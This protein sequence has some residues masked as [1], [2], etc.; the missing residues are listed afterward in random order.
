M[1]NTKTT[2]TTGPLIIVGVIMVIILVVIVVLSLNKNN[3][4]A[5]T[6]QPATPNVGQAGDQNAA[7]PEIKT[8]GKT[9]VSEPLMVEGGPLWK[10][11]GKSVPQYDVRMEKGVFTPSRMIVKAGTKIQMAFQAVD[12]AYDFSIDQPNVQYFQ[13]AKGQ[14]N[15]IVFD[16][17]AD[18]AGTYT[19][20][21][22]DMCPSGQKME[23]QIII[24]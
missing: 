17:P 8:E 12:A 13:V 4:S 24:Q 15:I 3:S 11:D 19:F 21:C 6:D 7:A 2:K 1:E 9:E 20:S 16:A 22:K 14:T 10:K 5:P 23:G 18:K